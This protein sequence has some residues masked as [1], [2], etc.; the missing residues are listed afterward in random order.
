MAKKPPS[1]HVRLARAFAIP[2]TKRGMAATLAA[3]FGA[4]GLLGASIAFVPA[5]AVV[6]AVGGFAVTDRR[7][8]AKGLRELDKWGF[9][10]EGY[11]GWLLA[12]EPTFDVDLLREIDIDMIITSCAAID[13]AIVVRRISERSFRVVTRRIALPGLKDGDPPVHLGDRRLLRVLYERM[14]SPLHADIGIVAMRMGDRATLAS[15]VPTAA[16]GDDGQPAMLGMGAFREPAKAAPPA[17]QALVHSG[18]TSLSL[19]AET[20]KLPFRS[21]RVLHAAGRS[22]AGIGTVLAITAGGMFSGVQFGVIGAGIG[23]VGGFIGGIA[24]AVANNRRNVRVVSSLTGWQ[25]FEIDGYDDWLIAGRPLFDIELTAPIDRTAFAAQL[26]AIVAFS[27]EANTTV[28]WVTEITWL[29]ETL[30]R[31]ESRPT[32]IQPTSARIRAFYGGSHILFQQ[33]LTTVLIPLHNL[34]K[35]KSVHMGGYVERRV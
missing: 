11:R 20:R 7:V 22:P 8:I 32:L 18:G 17:L 16:L 33:C 25:G 35:I 2:P 9:P 6:A 12:A 24:A 5:I 1:D 14:L 26:N 13:P 28:R 30:V 15:I 21:E 31:V 27:G 10:I 19:T 34:V 4:A 3:G 29:E 23:A